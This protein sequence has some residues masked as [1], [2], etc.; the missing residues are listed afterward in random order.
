MYLPQAR[1]RLSAQLVNE[2][3]ADLPVLRERVGLPATT[4]EGDHVLAHHALVQRMLSDLAGQFRDKG[5]VL[6]TAELE[7]NEVELDLMSLPGQR[8]ADGV[9]PLAV[10]ADKRYPVPGLQCVLKQQRAIV[11]ITSEARLIHQVAEPVQID[12]LRVDDRLV[13][14]GLARDGHVPCGGDHPPQQGDV[15]PQGTDRVRGKTTA[16]P[17]PVNQLV[18]RHYLISLNQQHRQHGALAGMA[19]ADGLAVDA[20]L[21]FTKQA[22]FDFHFDLLS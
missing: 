10:Q 21:K 5:A 15:H 14:S 18:Y 12:G 19:N 3:L 1:A 13:T 8:A 4:V 9:D 6:A 2:A 17:Y 22:K 11:I 16:L 20:H 7:V